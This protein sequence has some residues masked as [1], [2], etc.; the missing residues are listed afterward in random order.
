MHGPC[1]RYLPLWWTD[2]KPAERATGSRHVQGE[3]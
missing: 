3:A 2:G 1:V